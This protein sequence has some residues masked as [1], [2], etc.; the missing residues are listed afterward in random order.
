[1]DESLRNMWL[2]SIIVIFIKNVYFLPVNKKLTL[3]T[4]HISN[5][6]NND[7]TIQY[8]NVTV[9]SKYALKHNYRFLKL[10][11]NAKKLFL[12]A[13]MLKFQLSP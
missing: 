4:I 5:V 11:Q 9:E 12:R 10:L 13:T 1:M 6:I 7:V 8:F 2:S 3:P